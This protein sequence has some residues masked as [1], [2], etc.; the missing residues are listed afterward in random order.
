LSG[1]SPHH[2]EAMPSIALSRPNP[3][4]A[5]DPAIKPAT[6][7]TVPSIVSQPSD[8]H[9]SILAKRARRSQL[10]RRPQGPGA[11]VPQRKV[12]RLHVHEGSGRTS[13][14]IQRSRRR[15]HGH[16]AAHSTGTIG[17]RTR[18]PGSP[19]RAN[20]SPATREIAGNRGKRRAPE[21]R[22][23]CRF[24]RLSNGCQTN[25]GGPSTI[26]ATWAAASAYMPGITWAY[27][28]SVNAGDSWPS[29]SLA[30]WR[31]G[32]ADGSGSP[33]DAAPVWRMACGSV[34]G[35]ARLRASWRP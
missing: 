33:R 30:R 25:G 20:R 24:R 6:T 1:E 31:P 3:T 27:W 16:S 17:S 12:D 22:G 9:A 8:A 14:A 21:V 13:R 29:R 4:S 34:S 10:P 28:L 35:R 19:I 7:P 2:T 15:Y 32:P 26:A 11:N 23:S 5:I 18:R